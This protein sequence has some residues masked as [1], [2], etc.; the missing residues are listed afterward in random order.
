MRQADA[1]RAA[2]FAD[3]LPADVLL[4]C[5]IFGN[6]SDSDIERT[7]AAAPALCAVAPP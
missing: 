1:G 4:L 7:V 3:A 5:G 6:V 2:S